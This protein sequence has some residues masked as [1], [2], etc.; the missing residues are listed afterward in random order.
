MMGGGFLISKHASFY[1]Q[2]LSLLSHHADIFR[3]SARILMKFRAF[4]R[5]REIF[6]AIM[7]A[8]LSFTPGGYRSMKCRRILATKR[9]IALIFSARL[10]SKANA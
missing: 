9:S 5:G 3:F 4:R 8:D 10:D 6:N 2:I 1:F 7:K